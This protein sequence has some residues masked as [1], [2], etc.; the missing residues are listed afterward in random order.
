M[1]GDPAPVAV[2]VKRKL[3][4]SEVDAL[5]IAWHGRYLQFFEDAHTELMR[6]VGLTYENYGKSDIGEY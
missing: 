5:A 1:P 4:F 2:E 6:K 3:R